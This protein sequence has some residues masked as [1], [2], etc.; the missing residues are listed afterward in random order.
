VTL[1]R[2]RLE[3]L[4]TFGI[5][6]GIWALLQSCA[7][8]WARAGFSGLVSSR[9]TE[10]LGWGF[11]ANAASIAVLARGPGA[12]RVGRVVPWAVIAIWMSA[13][14]GSEIW[15]SRVIYDPYLET[16]RDQTREHE[17]RLGTFMRTGDASVIESVAFP[18]IPYMAAQII[19]VLRDTLVQPLLPAP[20]RRDLVRDRQ[21]ELLPGVRDGP[22]SFL[23][24]H[25]LG[26]G[27]PVAG[28]GVALLVGAFMLSRRA[29]AK[30]RLGDSP[31][32][33]GTVPA[34]VLP[35]RPGRYRA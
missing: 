35:R 26:C 9:Y 31:S 19:P 32:P 6:L 3:P 7:L 33:T 2:R 22:L 29:A 1:R 11:V 16:F 17:R 23:A 8:G 34:S 14:G 10:F 24:I 20:L 18:R 25:V 30:A 5:G 4:A 28:A 13:V 12:T 15:R 21:P 27:P